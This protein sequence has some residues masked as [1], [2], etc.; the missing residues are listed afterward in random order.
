[1]WD[2]VA[3]SRAMKGGAGLTIEVVQ[4]LYIIIPALALILS[5]K[6]ELPQ[7]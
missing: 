4:L 2:V 6:I 1:M 3:A 5:F 7:S